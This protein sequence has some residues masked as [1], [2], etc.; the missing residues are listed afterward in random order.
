MGELGRRDKYVVGWR[1]AKTPIW[2]G[3]E[4]LSRLMT[5]REARRE[6]KKDVYASRVRVFKLVTV[7]ERDPGLLRRKDQYVIGLL[8]SGTSIYGGEGGADFASLF[9]LTLA[10][11]LSTLPLV[12]ARAQV[13]VLLPLGAK[14]PKIAARLARKDRYV[15]GWHKQRSAIWGTSVDVGD[16]ILP[17]SLAE[18]KREAIKIDEEYACVFELARFIPR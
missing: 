8:R 12:G 13:F 11:T 1:S 14:L 4:S 10:Q 6:V 15:V 7:E 18:A 5:L 2:S 9:P 16:E 3:E 17:L